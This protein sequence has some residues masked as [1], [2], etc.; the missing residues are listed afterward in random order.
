M[1]DIEVTSEKSATIY[2]LKKKPELS[3]MKY[4]R[5]FTSFLFNKAIRETVKK[6]N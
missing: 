4:A 6:K 5:Y 2:I 1:L 3:L